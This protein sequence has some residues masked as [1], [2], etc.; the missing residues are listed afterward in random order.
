MTTARSV[1][2][3]FWLELALA[4]LTAVA[5]I[6]TILWPAWIEAVFGIDL[7]EG[8]GTLELAVTLAIALASI[9]LAAIARTEW[10]RTWRLASD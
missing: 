7:D 4:L 3:R 10:R 8:N 5:A 2:V 6:A 9:T 1:R